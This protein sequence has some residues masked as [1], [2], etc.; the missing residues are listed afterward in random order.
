M[1]DGQG[2]ELT[3]LFFGATADVADARSVTIEMPAGAR[4]GDAFRRI[5]SAY[6][7]LSSHKLL[8]SLNEVY[9]QGDEPLSLGDELAIFTAVSG[10]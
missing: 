2:I 3:I 4:S 8:Y 1:S 9:A 7:A 10:G 5:V 6:P